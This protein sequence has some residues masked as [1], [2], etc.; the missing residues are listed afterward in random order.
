[1]AGRSIVGNP[2]QIAGQLREYAAMGVDEFAFPDWNF[3]RTQAER[4]DLIGRLASE[5]IPLLG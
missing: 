2:E 5:V 3:G 4:S 1:M